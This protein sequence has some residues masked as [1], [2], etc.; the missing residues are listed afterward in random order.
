MVVSQVVLKIQQCLKIRRASLFSIHTEPMRP[1]L[2]PR[3]FQRMIIE[4][5]VEH[6]DWNNPIPY[7]DE[8]E[9][10]LDTF[11]VDDYILKVKQEM[12]TR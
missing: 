8:I 5:R 11:N 6:R 9:E 1:E 2:Y 4:D 7:I 10:A 3:D 12:W